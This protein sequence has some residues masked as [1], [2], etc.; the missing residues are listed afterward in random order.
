[1]STLRIPRWRQPRLTWQI[2]ATLAL[3]LLAF[4]AFAGN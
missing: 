2:A 1:M 4:G 3:A